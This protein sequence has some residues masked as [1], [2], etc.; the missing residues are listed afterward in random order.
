MPDQSVMKVSQTIYNNNVMNDAPH[1]YS[2]RLYA[3]YEE[4]KKI[5]FAGTYQEYLE[6]RDFT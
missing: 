5:G 6:L 2:Q 1:S 4:A 3:E